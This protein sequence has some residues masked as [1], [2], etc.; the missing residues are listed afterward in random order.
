MTTRAVLSIGLLLAACGEDYPPCS[1]EQGGEWGPSVPPRDPNPGPGLPGPLPPG[2][3]PTLYSVNAAG[4]VCECSPYE[5]GCVDSPEKAKQST[6]KGAYCPYPREGGDPVLPSVGEIFSDPNRPYCKCWW[7]AY[8][9]CGT[10]KPFSIEIYGD[11]ALSCVVKLREMLDLQN[12]NHQTP[13]G[14]DLDSI[15]CVSR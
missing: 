6:H 10:V 15:Q 2:D 8:D 7:S 14:H 1:P 3:A 12:M 9:A 4:E 5:L 13:A 11:S